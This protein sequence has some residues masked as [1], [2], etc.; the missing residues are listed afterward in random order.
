MP[1]S[2]IAIISREQKHNLSSCRKNLI[3]T[4][5][6]D[7]IEFEIGSAVFITFHVTD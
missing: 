2:S 1:S 5:E 7:Y 4:E 6:A 3:G